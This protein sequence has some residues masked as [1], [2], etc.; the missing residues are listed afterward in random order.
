MDGAN[1]FQLSRRVYGTDLANPPG[2]RPAARGPGHDTNGSALG[3]I[4]IYRS[5]LDRDSPGPGLGYGNGQRE[6]GHDLGRDLPALRR[7]DDLL[8]DFPAIA[9][10]LE[11]MAQQ[12]RTGSRMDCVN[13][14]F[15][16]AG[17]LFRG[18]RDRAQA[19]PSVDIDGERIHRGRN[20]D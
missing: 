14:K 19:Q 18:K 15:D 13:P 20:A 16:R 3:V 7:Q 6:L 9:P 10:A 1:H 11:S 2:E 12:T 5:R 4:A 17:M 8:G